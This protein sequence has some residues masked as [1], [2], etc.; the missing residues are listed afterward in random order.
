LAERDWSGLADA[1]VTPRR[2]PLVWDVLVP[3]GSLH[4]IEL[5]PGDGAFY[6]VSL[7]AEP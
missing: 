7:T 2:P 1:Q 4:R 6:V 5:I 3:D